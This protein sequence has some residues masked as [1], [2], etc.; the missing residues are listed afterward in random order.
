MLKFIGKSRLRVGGL[1][2]LICGALC[3]TAIALPAAADQPKVHAAASTL[4]TSKQ[5]LRTARSAKRLAKRA[6]KVAGTGGPQGPQG[7][8]G[9][10]GTQGPKGETGT[11]GPKGEPGTPGQKG[12][13]GTPA[14]QEWG[15]VRSDGT[16]GA[17]QGVTGVTH[18]SMGN[19]LVSFDRPVGQVC[20]PVVTPN[21]L[22]A[23]K[24]TWT[25][26][27]TTEIGVHTFNA[28]NAA[29]DVNFAIVLGCPPPS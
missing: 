28:A 24:A 16:I 15:W 29:T 9:E 3:T 18:P 12:D 6:L 25:Y 22:A 13:P 1:A 26:A 7:V 8:R 4:K 21:T 5:A 11:Q 10:T 23:F 27:S 2:V 19:Y 20:A 17:S 14:S